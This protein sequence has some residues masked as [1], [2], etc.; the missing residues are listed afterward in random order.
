MMSYARKLRR[1]KRG[2][3]EGWMPVAKMMPQRL[4]IPKFEA[5]H[6]WDELLMMP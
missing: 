4:Y 3:V 2:L 5:K 6:W 1:Q